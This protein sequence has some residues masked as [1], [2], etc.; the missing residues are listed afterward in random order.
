MACQAHPANN[1]RYAAGL[2]I[3]V[4]LHTGSI[5]DKSCNYDDVISLDDIIGYQVVKHN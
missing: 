3:T 4:A 5:S 2:P 1:Y